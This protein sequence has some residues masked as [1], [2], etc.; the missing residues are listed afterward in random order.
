MKVEKELVIRP[1]QGWF[2]VNLK[3]IWDYRDLIWVFIK[4]N[5]KLIYKQTILGPAWLVLN[6]VITSVIFTFVFG[7][8]AGIS[9][10]GVPQFL[11]YMAG[12]TLWSLFST[13]VISNSNIFVTNASVYGKIYFPRLA[14]PIAQTI[15]GFINSLIQFAALMVIFVAYMLMGEN[16]GFS[17]RM[18]I[19]PVIFLQVLLLSF[20]IGLIAS[21]ISA[22]YRDF[23]F[24][25]VLGM[26]LWMYVTPVVYPMSLTGGWMYKILLLNPVTPIINNFKWALLG[27]GEI[28]LWSWGLSAVVTAVLLVIGLAAFGK[29]EKNFID[30]V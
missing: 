1:Q 7:Q 6:P 29:V 26:Q 30:T 13:G 12:N 28:M 22:K 2:N 5:F 24:M 25:L 17:T 23:E 19:I 3:E 9:T 27:S 8:F 18:V 16:I 11:F 4:K 10:D 20:A 14:S 15:S 21:S